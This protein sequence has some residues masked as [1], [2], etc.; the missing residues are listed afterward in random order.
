[1]LDAA[2]GPTQSPRLPESMGTESSVRTAVKDFYERPEIVRIYAQVGFTAAEGALVRRFFPR[3]ASVLDVGSG[4]GRSAIALAQEGYQVTG[5]DLSAAMV[6]QAE[7]EAERAN[8]EARFVVGDAVAL[9]FAAASFDAAL[10]AGNGIGHLEPEGK[11]R[12]LR[13]LARVLTPGGCAIISTRTPY[14][15]NSLLP[16]HLARRLVN[17]LPAGR[18]ETWSAGVYVHN[19]SLRTHARLLRQAGFMISSTTSH[20]AAAAGRDPGPLTLWL[21]GQFFF[22]GHLPQSHGAS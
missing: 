18:D 2:Q 5:V 4:A 17:T 1:M 14:A 15:L 16:G 3:G 6:E 20:R 10:F 22:V 13:E 7:R 21:G 19:P 12:C 9:P 8:V 11:L